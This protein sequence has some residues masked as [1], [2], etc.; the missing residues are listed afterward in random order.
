MRDVLDP[1]GIAT[2]PARAPREE[3][4]IDTGAL[5]WA[6]VHRSIDA[7]RQEFDAVQVVRHEDLSREPQREFAALSARLGLEFGSRSARTVERATTASRSETPVG[8]P[9]QVR[10][11]S[12]ANLDNW[13]RRLTADEVPRIDEL[14]TP[15]AARFYP[16]GD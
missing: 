1:L 10:L 2:G 8:N 3:R 9:H 7:S 15:V 4:I 13:R 5:L 11:D 12:R 16:E 14:T 6:A